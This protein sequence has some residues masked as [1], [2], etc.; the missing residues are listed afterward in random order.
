MN[1]RL[2]LPTLLL[3]NYGVSAETLETLVGTYGGVIPLGTPRF[4]DVLRWTLCQL[5]WSSVSY[6]LHEWTSEAL[7]LIEVSKDDFRRKQIQRCLVEDPE[8]LHVVS[9]IRDLM[10]YIEHEA[11]RQGVFD[12]S[13]EDALNDKNYPRDLR[14]WLACLAAVNTVSAQLTEPLNY[15]MTGGVGQYAAIWTLSLYKGLER[16][17]RVQMYCSTAAADLAAFVRTWSTP[18]EGLN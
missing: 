9:A 6:F 12:T 4:Q 18:A 16:D 13:V 8:E 3:V 2:A 10:R 1:E 7:D 11:R 15:H 5:P 14:A 17:R